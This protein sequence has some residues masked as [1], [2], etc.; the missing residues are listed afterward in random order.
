MGRSII[1]VFEMN[2]L[3]PTG[4]ESVLPTVVVMLCENDT[5]E[6]AGG[7]LLL[8]L[9]RIGAE[10]IDKVVVIVHVN[11]CHHTTTQ[12]GLR[13]L[14]LWVMSMSVLQVSIA[15]SVDI[16]IKDVLIEFLLLIFFDL[17]H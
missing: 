3:L 12:L 15:G 2:H 11:C 9:V 13:M 4:G 17:F 8:L 16:L 1:A 10:T 14:Q 7:L 6:D 5:I